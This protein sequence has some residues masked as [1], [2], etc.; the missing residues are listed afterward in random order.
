M[1]TSL[2]NKFEEL[3]M[4]QDEINRFTEAMKKEEFRKLLIEYAE[5]ISDPK[6]RELYEQEI[7]K[8]EE[9]RGVNCTFI[10]PEP[11]YCVKTI[12][13]GDKKCFIN[14]CKNSNI[15]KPSAK[16]DLNNNKGGLHWQIPHSCS[17]ARDDIDKSNK[18]CV[19]YDVVFNPDAYRMGETNQRFNQLLRDSAMDTI[20]Q[21]YNVKLDKSN[22]KVLKN[23]NFKGR[24][25]ASV[26]RRP[27][28][29]NNT[30]EE[31]K[32][33]SDDDPIE[34]IVDQLKAQY[35]SNQTEQKNKIEKKD[36]DKIE[37]EKYTKPNYKITYRGQ[38][39][40]QDYAIQKDSNYVQSTRPRELFIS[41][42][43]PLCK[44]SSDVILDIFE[45]RLYLE[46]NNPFYKLDLNLSYPVNEKESKAKFDKSKRCLN[47]TLPVIPFVAK[48]EHKS[49][50]ENLPF[51]SSSSSSS[52]EEQVVEKELKKLDNSVQDSS[53]KYLLPTKFELKQ[54][55]K[56]IYLQIRIE[57]FDKKSIKISHEN[58]TCVLL[59][60]E[61]ISTSGTYLTYY[62]AYI[63][64]LGSKIK[65][66]Q[67][68]FISD[69]LFQVIFE[70]VQD[71]NKVLISSKYTDTLPDEMS[72]DVII[73]DRL[74][75]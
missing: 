75:E 34:K 33:P 15:D 45:K 22:A 74:N 29:T 53:I 36:Q 17:P 23:L 30:K 44:S 20:E 48:L 18:P 63:N 61:S 32:T 24:P 9:E 1:S 37:V 57:N 54:S 70:S 4:S 6:N 60:C 50:D 55:Q 25:T 72:H 38:A 49:D 47:V 52:E 2:K 21:N 19:V 41:I 40:M 71:C 5:E 39:D 35:L 65:Y 16:R 56:R 69:D 3:N 8:L 51:S 73:I 42:E 11:G 7:T 13:N 28:N 67:I 12:Q 46:S 62:K 43:L 64:F 66:D 58:D 31:I 10:H 27:N 14:I 68:N 26:I 59:T